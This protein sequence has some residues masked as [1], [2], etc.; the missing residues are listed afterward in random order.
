MIQQSDSLPK[1]HILEVVEEIYI[2][3]GSEG[4]NLQ[5][6]ANA[7]RVSVA[8]VNHCLSSKSRL[9]D[10]MVPGRLDPIHHER[11]VLLDQ[12]EAECKD[13]FSVVH[14]LSALLIPLITRMKPMAHD[15]RLSRFYEHLSCDATPPIRKMMEQRYL[16][17]S[18]A[19]NDA[20]VKSFPVRRR[21]DIL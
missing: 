2:D 1:G 15:R 9:I 7:A 3:A 17:I 6:I 4:L 13:D 10:E 20:F 16:F 5:T 12:M 8:E 14:V 21:E 11:L 18:E 19:F